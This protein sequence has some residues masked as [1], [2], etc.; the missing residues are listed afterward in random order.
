MADGTI[1]DPK[2]TILLKLLKPASWG[3][4]TE[5]MVLAQ[6]ILHA[7]QRPKISGDFDRTVNIIRVPSNDTTGENT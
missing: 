4:S 5:S 1:R 3:P 2:V 6:G 7:H